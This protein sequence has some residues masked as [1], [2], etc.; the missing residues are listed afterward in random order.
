MPKHKISVRPGCYGPFAMVAYEHLHQIGLEYVEIDVPGNPK[1]I[2]EIMAE[3]E[4]TF[5]IGSFVFEIKT[6]DPNIIEKF[7]SA[8]ETC[9]VFDF[10]YFFSS[11]KTGGIFKKNKEQGYK[12]LHK[13]G[14]IA[15]SYGK[16]ISMETH[17]PY[18]VNA[19]E[20]LQTMKAVDHKCVRINF[21]TANIY[22]YNKLKP[23]EGISEMEQVIDY[24][25]SFHLK[26]TNGQPK[27][28]F[29][30]P[31]GYPGGIIDFKKIFEIMDKK[32][33]DGFYTLEIEGIRGEP[34]LTMDTAKKRIE[35]ALNHFK[36]IGAF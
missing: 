20:M 31:P 4:T 32:G 2:Q 21:D 25:G 36:N 13:L 3:E 30:P 33:F 18:C 19:K 26:E 23:G 6:D 34:P 9:K 15:E 16:F 11:T 22:Y 35:D 29:F 17:P 24:I 5:K 27:G 12:I 7:K 28:W 8:C 10:T 14:D 1:L